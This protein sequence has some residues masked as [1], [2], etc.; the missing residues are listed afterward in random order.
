[1]TEVDAECR[2]TDCLARPAHVGNREIVA[3]SFVWD[4]AAYEALATLEH[5]VAAGKTAA[6]EVAII[7]WGSHGDV[8]VKERIGPQLGSP[9]LLEMVAGLVCT[10]PGAVGASTSKASPLVEDAREPPTSCQS[11]SALGALAEMVNG[12]ATSMLADVAQRDSHVVR[13]ELGRLGGEVRSRARDDIEEEVH[14]KAGPL[15]TRPDTSTDTSL[16]VT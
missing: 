7:E 5:L 10:L 16:P 11:G 2:H 9:S 12:G 13:L 6:A 1:M 8:V 4:S 15:G 3:A 14:S